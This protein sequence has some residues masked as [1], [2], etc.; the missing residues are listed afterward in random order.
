MNDHFVVLPPL[1]VERG[2][3]HG[4]TNE[5]GKAEY[6]A[7]HIEQPPSIVTVNAPAL[8]PSGAPFVLK[9]GGK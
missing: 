2:L 1:R 4:T 3:N 8:H 7:P 6:L 9:P 5:C